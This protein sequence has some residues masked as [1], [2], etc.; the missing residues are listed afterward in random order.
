M[1][2]AT[3][4][5]IPFGNLSGSSYW[6]TRSLFF[7]DGTIITVGADKYFK[8]RSGA[9]RNFLITGYDFDSTWTKGFPYKS[10]ATI[11]A[12]AGDAALIAADIN[13]FLYDAGGTPNAIPVVS[14]FQNIDYENTIFCRHVAQV[15]D[16]NGVETYEPRVLEIFMTAAPLSAAD[17]VKTNTYFE[18]PAEITTTVK[19]VSKTGLDTNPGTKAL[20]WLTINKANTSATAGDTVYIKSGTYYEANAGA[21]GYLM[22]SN[23]CKF[24]GI[25]NI[26]VTTE[27]TT[28]G[29]F[30]NANNVWFEGFCFYEAQSQ[31]SLINNAKTG[32]I[33]KRCYIKSTSGK[34]ARLYGGSATDCIFS[35]GTYGIEKYHG[36]EL[37]TVTNCLCYGGTTSGL[38]AAEA[39]VQ[40]ITVNNSKLSGAIGLG[41]GSTVT[42]IINGSKIY[43]TT[44]PMAVSGTGTFTFTYCHIEKTGT[45]VSNYLAATGTGTT[46]LVIDNCV[47]KSAKQGPIILKN[48]TNVTFTNNKVISQ[49]TGKD[50]PIQITTVTEST[51]FEVSGN[52]ITQIDD[53]SSTMIIGN[54][55]MEGYNLMTGTIHSNTFLGPKYYNYALVPSIHMV[56]IFNQLNVN[57]YDNLIF[58]GSIG[59][60]FKHTS[61]DLT[62]SSAHHNVVINCAKGICS[63]GGRN[64][65]IYNNTIYNDTAGYQVYILDSGVNEDSDGCIVKNNILFEN[66][67]AGTAS[68]YYFIGTSTG[69]VFENNIVFST[70]NDI[71][72]IGD[73]GLAAWQALGYDLDVINSNPLLTDIVNYVL[74]LQALSPAIGA[75]EDLGASYN[76]GLDASTNWG[77]DTQLPVVVTKQQGAAWDIGAYVH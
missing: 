54:E 67:P 74:S 45:G 61:G 48:Y 14:L 28:Y 72:N 12:P 32:L 77:S 5:G 3:V 47:I 23:A 37:L 69:L 42:A 60:V 51:V 26:T 35:G 7:L 63:K 70:N 64:L 17:L 10:A 24:I 18:I 16:G 22:L 40:K 59:I 62:P 58:G 20:P 71:S 34:A 30:I 53:Y 11:S 56:P 8:D 36:D 27:A 25:G 13:N 15:V 49:G 46:T 9:A 44:Y 6:T 33:L 50:T 52:I 41:V 76:D 55:I 31:H 43:G 29:I 2:I 1:A 57:V 19:W 68:N 73:G 38:S 21:T 65:K 4:T 75:G 66:S 39:G